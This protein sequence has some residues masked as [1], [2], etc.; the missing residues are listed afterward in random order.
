VP[1]R[2]QRF[3]VSPFC[4]E[5]EIFLR[6][7]R[8][9]RLLGF[10]RRVFGRF[11]RP[12]Q[13]W[14]APRWRGEPRVR[15]LLRRY[16]SF[17]H[18]RHSPGLIRWL[19]VRGLRAQARVRARAQRRARATLRP[20]IGVPL[21]PVDVRIPQHRLVL[22]LLGRFLRLPPVQGRQQLELHLASPRE[23]VRLYSSPAVARRATLWYLLAWLQAATGPARLVAP[24]DS[25]LTPRF[26]L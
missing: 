13:A 2:L 1:R 17:L 5:L 7:L 18:L 6:G 3:Y 9:L 23:G 16:V 22:V 21:W 15:R 11:G 19:S 12:P 10:F 8:R 4:R 20:L 25:R 26:W 24:A 14:L